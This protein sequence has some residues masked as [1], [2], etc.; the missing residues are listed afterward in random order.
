MKIETITISC[1]GYSRDQE[2]ETFNNTIAVHEG[3]PSI[4]A[5]WAITDIASG[6]AIVRHTDK[7]EAIAFAKSISKLS[8]WAKIGGDKSKMAQHEIDSVRQAFIE[9]LKYDPLGAIA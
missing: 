4:G 8:F 9:H 2:A 1:H 7:K 6:K 5:K 3:Y